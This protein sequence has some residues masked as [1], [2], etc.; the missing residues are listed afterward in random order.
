[1]GS[2]N[3][4]SR[5][6]KI[7]QPQ[8]IPGVESFCD[9]SRIVVKIMVFINEVFKRSGHFYSFTEYV[10]S[11]KCSLLPDLID[12]IF[13]LAMTPSPMDQN[14]VN[15]LS[16]NDRTQVMNEELDSYMLPNKHAHLDAIFHHEFLKH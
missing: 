2:L 13:K 7:S 9:L 10:R 15:L 16:D 12:L 5:D 1:M 6:G 8:A 3:R 14:I 4:P 11:S